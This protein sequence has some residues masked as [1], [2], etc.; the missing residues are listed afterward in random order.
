[1][2]F[3][4]NTEPASD[5]TRERGQRRALAEAFQSPDALAIISRNQRRLLWAASNQRPPSKGTGFFREDASAFACGR[6]TGWSHRRKPPRNTLAFSPARQPGV[7]LPQI[8]QAQRVLENLAHQ[9]VVTRQA[10]TPH[11]EGEEFGTGG[12]E[13]CVFIVFKPESLRASPMSRF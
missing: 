8:G 4:S 5:E 3:C 1:M 6:G 10:S 7:F 2:A 11:P 9:C 12:R 13:V